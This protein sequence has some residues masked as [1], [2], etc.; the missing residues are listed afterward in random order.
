MNT[1]NKITKPPWETR[2]NGFCVDENFACYII[3]IF[4]WIFH[5]Y[6]WIFPYNNIYIY[7][8]IIF[9]SIFVNRMLVLLIQFTLRLIDDVNIGLSTG[10]GRACDRPLPESMMWEI[11]GAMWRCFC[12]NHAIIYTHIYIFYRYILQIC[13]I[14]PHDIMWHI[15]LI[16]IWI[17]HRLSSHHIEIGCINL[18]PIEME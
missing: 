7:T 10:F 8:D 15:S 5:I 17:L 14:L 12:I 2:S 3:L 9:N 11:C 6:I 18:F 13:H 16:V 4:R 1:E